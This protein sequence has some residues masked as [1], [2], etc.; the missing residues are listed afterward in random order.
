MGWL[1]KSEALANLPDLIFRKRVSFRCDGLPLLSE[2]LSRHQRINL[3]RTGIDMAVGRDKAHALPPAVQIEPTNVCNLQC[4]LCPTGTGASGRAKGFMSYETFR[5][6]M[7]EIGDT[8]LF[9]IL[10]GWGEPFLN[11][12]LPRMIEDCTRRNICTL[13]STNG[14][15]LQSLDETLRVVDAGLSAL[16]IAIDGSTQDIYNVYRKGG[17]VEKVKRCISLIEE[18][19]ARRGSK[20]PYTNLRVVVT[21]NNYEDLPNLE[22]L[23]REMGVNMFSYKSLGCLT[24]SGNFKN[25]EPEDERMR[26]FEYKGSLRN[27]RS[28]LHCPYPFRQ[29][30]V[31]WDGTVVGCEFDYDLQ[32]PWGKVDR[33]S[34]VS[35][36]NSS[37]AFQMRR[38]IL[39]GSSRLPF[40]KACPYRDRVQKDSVLTCKELRGPDA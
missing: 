40:C 19:K 15:C 14:N 20:L 28:P 8:L 10:Y 39:E 37:G 3:I 18:A 17:S 22:R 4:P 1:K 25:F 7:E 12:A 2:N 32:L 36:W 38:G 23:A 34:F 6:I 26:R 35:I 27:R 16:I 33:Q 13:T 9:A 11:K 5:R 30:T 29:P 21:R 31:F 24:E